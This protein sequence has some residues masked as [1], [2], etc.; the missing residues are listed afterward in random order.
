MTSRRIAFLGQKPIGAE[1]LRVL[2]DFF[3]HS[4]ILF[5]LTNLN[6]KG[7]W[8]DC[9]VNNIAKSGQIKVFEQDTT[10]QLELFDLILKYNVNTI[11]SVQ[12]PKILSKAVL[13]QVNYQAF[14][15]HLAK[16]PE[17]RGWHSASHAILNGDKTFGVTIHKIDQN[18]DSGEIISESFFEIT[19]ECTVGELYHQSEIQGLHLFKNFCDKLALNDIHGRQ[20]EGTYRY[21][22]ERSLG[23]RLSS[24][25]NKKAVSRSSDFTYRL[26]NLLW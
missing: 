15:L 5:V 18:I 16:L 23:I 6:P 21:Y 1:C 25:D 14:N 2:I 10:T 22:D 17:Y 20:Q 11:I 26:N 24:I 4:S 8:Q 7:W 3:G 19:K 12:Y 9:N 13:A